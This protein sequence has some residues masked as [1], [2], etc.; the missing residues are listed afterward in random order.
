M[1]RGHHVLHVHLHL[2]GAEPLLLA[3]FAGRDPA[4]TNT[5]DALAATA[6]A[7]LAAAAAALVSAAARRIARARGSKPQLWRPPLTRFPPT[8]RQHSQCVSGISNNVCFSPYEHILGS[9][10]YA[11]R[12]DDPSRSPQPSP[13]SPLCAERGAGA[14]T[15]RL[16]SA[17]TTEMADASSTTGPALSTLS[18]AGATVLFALGSAGVA[19]NAV[20]QTSADGTKVGLALGYTHNNNGRCFQVRL[21]TSVGDWQWP[22]APEHIDLILQSINTGLNN[23][24]DVYMA[25]GG[26]GAWSSNMAF[27]RTRHV[28]IRTAHTGRAPQQRCAAA[29]QPV[30]YCG[31]TCGARSRHVLPRLGQPPWL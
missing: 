25:Q 15:R 11:C 4:A 9:E 12:R 22:G 14:E 13:P 30:R 19:D 5:W 28:A 18:N 1:D 29:D 6:L 24:F 8:R 21:N 31:P 27:G 26:A 3:M 17:L 16:Q 10:A 23:A 2:Y 20:I 7:A